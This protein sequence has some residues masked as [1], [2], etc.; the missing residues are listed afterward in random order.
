MVR[1]VAC[2]PSASETNALSVEESAAAQEKELVFQ[3][4]MRALLE[5]STRFQHVDKRLKQ[6]RRQR[7]HPAHKLDGELMHELDCGCRHIFE[8]AAEK[9]NDLAARCCKRGLW[10]EKQKEMSLMTHHRARR[11]RQQVIEPAAWESK[12]K[13]KVV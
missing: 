6:A 4:Q 11:T 12:R 9:V 8:A 13:K 10:A 2:S 3:E 7:K 5:E 1:G